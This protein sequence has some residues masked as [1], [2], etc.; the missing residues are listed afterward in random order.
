M[1]RLVIA[2]AA[3]LP[4][5]LATPASADSVR[6]NAA[7]NISTWGTRGDD[8]GGCAVRIDTFDDRDVRAFCWEN[9]GTW[10]KVRVPGV[11][12]DV[13]RV[14]AAETGDCSGQRITW[15]KPNSTAIVRIANT[16]E[17]DC[18]YTTVVVRYS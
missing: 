4:L 8:Y 9:G 12:G 15:K 5:V 16:G 10:F 13:T 3:V 14:Q 2:I 1:R 7:E 18:R 6:V 17:F 11:D